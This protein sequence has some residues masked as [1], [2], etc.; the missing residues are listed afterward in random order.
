MLQGQQCNMVM[1]SVSGH[2]LGADF[3]FSLLIGELIAVNNPTPKEI[4]LI[5]HQD[6]WGLFVRLACC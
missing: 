6:N 4:L 1:T 5:C 3:D 2:L